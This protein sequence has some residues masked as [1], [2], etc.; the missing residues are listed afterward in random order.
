VL[1][2][3]PPGDPLWPRVAQAVA[4][5]RLVRG[6]SAAATRLFEQ[7]AHLATETGAPAVAADAAAGH[8]LVTLAAGELVA[9]RA[10]LEAAEARLR[11]LGPGLPLARTLLLQGELALCDG[12]FTEAEERGAEAARIARELPRVIT[13][14]RGLGLQ[15]SARLAQGDAAGALALAREGAAALHGRTRA[16][17]PPEVLA[18]VAVSRVFCAA[19]HPEEAAALLPP[20]PLQ[21]LAALED[22]VGQLL[23]LRAW[24]HG[25]RDPA[26]A[27]ESAWG[28]LGRTPAL[29]PTAAARIALDAA[30]ALA[31]MGDAAAEDAVLE[32]L[33]RTA[34]PGLRRL[35]LLALRV[36]LRV[37]PTHAGWLAAHTALAARLGADPAARGYT[38]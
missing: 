25:A 34:A 29:L 24:A 28:A 35:R 12:R 14:V 15:A 13:T 26:L 21:E 22:P 31:A 18:F 5:A 11:P 7:L 27:L 10:A 2:A 8:A 3:L 16:E 33:D 1:A 37:R 4:T 38:G 32:A 6:E 23:A 30:A 9:G 20:P 17:T 36:G 19:G